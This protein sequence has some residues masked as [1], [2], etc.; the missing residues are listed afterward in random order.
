MLIDQIGNVARMLGQADQKVG[1]DAY[2]RLDD[3]MK[4]LRSLEAEAGKLVG[5][6]ASEGGR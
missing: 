1:R 5:A 4:E 2:A 6:G 3:L